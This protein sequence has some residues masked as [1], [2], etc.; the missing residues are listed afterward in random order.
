MVPNNLQLSCFADDDSVR[1]TFKASD[2]NAEVDTKANVEQCMLNIKQWMDAAHLK[3]N[4]TKTEFIYFGHTAQLKKCTE[5]TI[6]IAS[7]LI[8][9][10]DTIKYLSVWMDQNLTLKQH[11]TKKCQNAML[12]F[13]KIRSIR[14]YLDNATTE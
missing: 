1:N 9:R 6:N 5:A 4:P 2:R 3:M 7:D 12:N 8:V 10:S 13:L 14:Q 11:I